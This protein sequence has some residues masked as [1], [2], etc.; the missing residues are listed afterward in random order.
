[1]FGHV[2]EQGN[3]HKLD[4]RGSPV[5]FIG[6]EDGVKAYKM[7]DPA[8]RRVRIARDVIFDEER[9]WD[10]T[11]DGSEY[12]SSNFGIEY[13]SR[14]A[15]WEPSQVSSSGEDRSVSSRHVAQGASASTPLS[16]VASAATPTIPEFVT[17][18]ADD[19]D[20]LDDAHCDICS[21]S[22]SR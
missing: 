18:L 16:L 2:K 21:L 3:L 9:G 14:H 20:R 8:T 15:T 4:D 22:Q 13:I 1:V 10:W 11:A 6:Y 19:D 5:V 7:L 17:P 12:S